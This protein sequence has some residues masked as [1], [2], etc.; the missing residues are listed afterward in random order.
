[1]GI[2]SLRGERCVFDATL[3]LERRAIDG[4]ALARA[5]VRVPVQGARP[6]AGIYREALRLH[7]RGAPF[8][9]HPGARPVAEEIR[10]T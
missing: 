5:C 10:P 4:C 2:R 9:P 3:A 6:L 7:R 1:V 8:H